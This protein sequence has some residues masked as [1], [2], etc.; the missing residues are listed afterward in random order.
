MCIFNFQLYGHF[1]I[2][3]DT[4]VH[5]LLQKLNENLSKVPLDVSTCDDATL[6]FYLR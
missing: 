6:S 4:F 2:L 1:H 3:T 5:A